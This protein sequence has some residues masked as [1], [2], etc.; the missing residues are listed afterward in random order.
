[1]IAC[2]SSRKRFAARAALTIFFL[3]AVAVVSCFGRKEMK[4]NSNEVAII[5]AKLVA[6][7]HRLR[8]EINLMRRFEKDLFVNISDA[9]S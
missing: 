4:H 3:A 5:H 7:S 8:A 6:G 9:V 1:M 2:C